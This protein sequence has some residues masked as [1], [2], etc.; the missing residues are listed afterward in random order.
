[1]RALVAKATEKTFIVMSGKLCGRPFAGSVAAWLWFLRGR[2]CVHSRKRMHFQQHESAMLSAGLIMWR[3]CVLI[4]F[5]TSHRRWPR[6]YKCGRLHFHFAWQTMASSGEIYDCTVDNFCLS[7]ITLTQKQV[8]IAS[9]CFCWLYIQCLQVHHIITLFRAI[10]HS[11]SW[12][13][14]NIQNIKYLLCHDIYFSSI[15][16]WQRDTECILLCVS[17]VWPWYLFLGT[18]N[19]VHCGSPHLL[20]YS[21]KHASHCSF[22]YICVFLFCFCFNP[23]SKSV[24]ASFIDT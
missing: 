2:F 1:M 19:I 11:V 7:N 5:L 10:S 20:T 17:T 3:P 16:A 22:R 4:H 13:L 21:I 9:H 12:N 8:K 15:I 14:N 18:R 6:S 24:L 23:N